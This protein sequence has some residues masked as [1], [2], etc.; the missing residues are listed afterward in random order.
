MSTVAQARTARKP[1][2][3]D[4][5]HFTPSLQGMA[6]IGPGHRYL[7]HVAFPDGDVNHSNR[8]YSINECVACACE[9]DPTAGVLMAGAC[10][11]FCCG[12]VPCARPL[13][14]NGGHGCR[15]CLT[16]GAA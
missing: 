10:S 16:G 11:T 8:P 9:R 1:Q 4:G 13:D 5:C 2:L 12:D 14:H 15:R 7:R 6:T 3:C